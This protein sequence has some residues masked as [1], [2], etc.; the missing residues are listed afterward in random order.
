[1]QGSGEANRFG[2][3]DRASGQPL[4][5][6]AIRSSRRAGQAMVEL[7]LVVPAL[8]L[9]LLSTVELGRLAY[10]GIGVTNAARA[11]VQYGSQ[12]S[13]TASDNAGMQ[14]AASNNAPNL[15]GMTATATHYCQCVNGSA[16]TCQPTDCQGSRRVLYVEVD[17]SYRFT[18]LIKY[19]GIPT[20]IQL[21]GKAV[22]R[23]PQ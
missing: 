12:N 7:A 1:M 2:L 10:A 8:V 17:T 15:T 20:P 19:P 4:S 18:T 16:S 22:S 6:W 23:V 21:S 3:F 13:T 11:G 5:R 14:Q 9:L